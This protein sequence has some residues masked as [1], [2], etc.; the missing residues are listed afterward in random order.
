[1]DLS[2]S[3][4]TARNLQRQQTAQTGPMAENNMLMLAVISAPDSSPDFRPLPL[5][6]RPRPRRCPRR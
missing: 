2:V 3:P 6:R 5:L 1:M 4:S